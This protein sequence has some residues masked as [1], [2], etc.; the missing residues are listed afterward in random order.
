MANLTLYPYISCL[1]PFVRPVQLFTCEVCSKMRP[2][3]PHEQ[4]L[5]ELLLIDKI[6]QKKLIKVHKYPPPKIQDC[7]VDKFSSRGRQRT[8]KQLST[9]FMCSVTKYI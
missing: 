8:R 3:I 1:I 6:K 2:S 9:A 5:G 4:G 7:T